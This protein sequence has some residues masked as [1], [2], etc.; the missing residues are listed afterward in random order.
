MT[1]RHPD[2]DVRTRVIRH[3]NYGDLVIYEYCHLLPSCNARE[4]GRST[5]T[6]QA[7]RTMS[8]GTLTTE[9]II[10]WAGGGCGYSTLPFHKHSDAS[11]ISFYHLR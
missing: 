2:S 3:L 5:N 10:Y 1:I 4:G 11:K 6:A 8:L 7:P 9:H